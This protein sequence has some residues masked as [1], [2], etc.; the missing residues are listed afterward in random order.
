MVIQILH[1][2]LYH[3]EGILVVVKIVVRNILF[4]VSY[5]LLKGDALIWGGL[6]VKSWQGS[7]E[8]LSESFADHINLRFITLNRFHCK[9]M[10]R[11]VK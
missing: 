10:V 4:A 2:A 7:R 6:V 1:F 9:V 11:R 5:D 3:E 8:T